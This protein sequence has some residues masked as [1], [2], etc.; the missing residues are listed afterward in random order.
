[1]AD[2]EDPMKYYRNKELKFEGDGMA[3]FSLKRPASQ[4][5]GCFINKRAAR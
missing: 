5:P 3:C 4:K 1:M 2:E